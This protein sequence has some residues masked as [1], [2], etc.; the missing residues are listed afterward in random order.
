MSRQGPPDDVADCI[1][2]QLAW[3]L[4]EDRADAIFRGDWPTAVT[5]TDMIS[6]LSAGFR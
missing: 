6:D 4:L 1:L 5:T 3:Q 2:C